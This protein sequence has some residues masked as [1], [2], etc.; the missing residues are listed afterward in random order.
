[1]KD[2]PSAFT[3]TPERI[4]SYMHQLLLGL[5]HCHAKGW[6]HRDIKTD[7]LL[8]TNTN[9]LSIAD[10]GLAKREIPG[11]NTPQVVTLWYRSPEVIYQ[12]ACAS[13]PIDV[14]SAGCV[15]GELLT[16]RPL[17]C[18]DD[19]PSQIVNIY[20]LCGVPDTDGWPGVHNLIVR[21]FPLLPLH[22]DV[23]CGGLRSGR[24]VCRATIC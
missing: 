6:V 8:V 11:R 21:L 4:C 24:V 7:N 3:M 23:Y 20:K 1:M 12:D 22:S 5:A 15:F 13:F 9:V 2:D 18:G 17:F 10:F 14:W 19:A 16:G